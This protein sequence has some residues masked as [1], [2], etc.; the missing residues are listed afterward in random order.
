MNLN[1]RN[2]CF[3]AKAYLKVELEP[4]QGEFVPL[5]DEESPVLRRLGN[6]LLVSYLVDEGEHFTYVLG[7]HLQEA[8]LSADELH[9]QALSNL[10]TFAEDNVTVHEYGK[11]YAS[12]GGEFEA[13]MVLC[14]DF[15][16]TWYAHLAPRGFVV[17]FPA[18]NVLAFGDISVPETIGELCTFYE[19][20]RPW[21]DHPLSPTLFRRVGRR[22]EPLHD[23]STPSVSKAS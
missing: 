9:A 11:I 4:G 21:R 14:E 23:G 17:S 13:S 5:D 7:R 1:S 22:W 2:F 8:G 12:I 15:W 6:G 19:Q 3:R 20:G 18:R 10:A 16:D